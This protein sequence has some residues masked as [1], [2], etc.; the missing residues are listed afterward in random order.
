M[1]IA[2][3]LMLAVAVLAV[4][5]LLWWLLIETEGVYLGRKTVIWLYDIYARRYDRIK[6]FS[7]VFDHMFLAAPL[8]EQVAPHRSP[9]VLDVAT[10]TGRLPLAL[11][12]HVDF[13]GRIIG[14]D[15]SRKMLQV[16]AAKLGVVGDRASWV[17]AP[18]EHLPFDD[19]TF[20]IV[21]C[22]EA[23]EF[24]IDRDAVLHEIV[25]VLRPGGVLLLTNR[26]NE[27]LMP[28]KLFTG[29]QLGERLEALGIVDVEI[30]RWQ[31]DYDRV[32]GR[33]AGDS[34]VTGARPLAEVLRCPC[35]GLVE[36]VEAEPA[37]CCTVCGCHLP[38]AND[39]VLDASRA[40][41]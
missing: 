37:W 6:E 29:R 15:L 26:I 10:G 25:R 21:T 28:G 17:C 19:D 12:Q 1:M 30:E 7:D 35:C 33:K 22:L 16:A 3:L 24:M 41:A 40:G 18:A 34:S 31:V 5:V 23:I 20:D 27:R 39:T 4:G 32:W 8:M 36:L 2:P 38:V 11:L 9:L 13:Q 14:V